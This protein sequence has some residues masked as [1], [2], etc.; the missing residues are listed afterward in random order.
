M[1]FRSTYALGYGWKAIN[2]RASEHSLHRTNSN[3]MSARTLGED[4]WQMR[5]IKRISSFVPPHSYFTN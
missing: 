5:L 3:P 2:E 4:D 1:R